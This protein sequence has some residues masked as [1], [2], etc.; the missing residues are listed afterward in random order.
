MIAHILQVP[1]VK[2]Y[3]RIASLILNKPIPLLD[4]TDIM[5][6]ER[7]WILV[8]NRKD[9]TPKVIAM[10]LSTT[11]EA[12]EKIVRASIDRQGHLTLISQELTE[13]ITRAMA[14]EKRKQRLAGA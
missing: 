8:T 5:Q 4:Y 10:E 6:A 11:L 13:E 14:Q 7:F 9:V 3:A 2:Y 12:A 1:I